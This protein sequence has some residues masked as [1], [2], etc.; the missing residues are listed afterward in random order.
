M[1]SLRLDRYLVAALLLA[2]LALRSQTA[3]LVAPK[4]STNLNA[5]AIPVISTI[6]GVLK[7]VSPSTLR[8]VSSTPIGA[9]TSTVYALNLDWNQTQGSFDLQYA[10]SAGHAITVQGIQSS[11]DIFVVSY[12]SS[13]AAG[14]TGT[15]SVLYSS[16]PETDSAGD[17]VRLMTSDGIKLIT[18]AH[19][20]PAVA[21]L[22]AAALSWQV[23]EAAAAKTV[24]LTLA[25]GVTA[26]G[27]TAMLGGQASVRNNGNGTFTISVIPPGTTKALS[28][29]VIVILT[30]AVPNVTPVI[31]CTVGS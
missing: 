3:V 18:L 17:V 9:Q 29:P 13:I 28:F 21:T 31:S 6:P 22:S 10:N 24:T 8:P 30:P 2:P 7:P 27:A 23:G 26:S 20:R 25:N 1:P 15:I 12:P 14:A 19:N 4:P 16:Q 5:P 11:G